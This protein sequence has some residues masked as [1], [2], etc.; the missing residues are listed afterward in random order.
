MRGS[1]NFCQGSPGLTAIKQS[2]KRFFLSF[3]SPQLILQFTEGSN[4]F[5]I[6]KT[7]FFP[8]IQRGV[9]HF[10]GGSNF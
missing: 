4:G 5:I 9:K 1:R 3:F 6:E 7:I 8:R 2:G 10:P